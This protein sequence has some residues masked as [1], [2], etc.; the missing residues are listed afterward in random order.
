[1][2]MRAIAATIGLANANRVTSAEVR[3]R[4]AVD[5]KLQEAARFGNTNSR[6]SR[7][8]AA[9]SAIGFA[10]YILSRV[11]R[12]QAVDFLERV[13]R[14]DRL[15]PSSPAHT[16]REKLLGAS[17]T[18]RDRKIAMIFKAWN[19]HRRGMKKLSPASL[20]STLPFP[21]LI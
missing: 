4:V 12:A 5:D 15:M 18:P 14:G 10:Y 17:T 20:N 13:C 2:A 9:G 7:Q 8:F 3:Q 6:Y 21:S 19:F 11:S 1:M 16:L